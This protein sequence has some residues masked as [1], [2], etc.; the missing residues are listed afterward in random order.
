M[1]EL[2]LKKLTLCL[3]ISSTAVISFGCAPTLPRQ[4]SP[5]QLVPHVEYSSPAANRETK[6]DYAQSI[7]AVL[8]SYL[9]HHWKILELDLKNGMVKAEW[10]D[11]K[12]VPNST[13]T[14]TLCSVTT[15]NVSKSDQ[16]VLLWVVSNQL[17]AVLLNRYLDN[18]DAWYSKYLT[19]PYAQLEQELLALG[20]D[21]SSLKAQQ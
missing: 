9:R 5:R 15:A 20:F 6:F 10:C 1:N 17:S 12:P 11:E 16:R 3:V 4:G 14:T 13:S 2:Q 7:A 18:V 21:L 19:Q 8:R